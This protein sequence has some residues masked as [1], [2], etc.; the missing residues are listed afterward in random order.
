[1]KNKYLKRSGPTYNAVLKACEVES[2]H[3][4]IKFE[5]GFTAANLNN[6]LQSLIINKWLV[7]T[8][9]NNTILYKA[10]LLELPDTAFFKSTGH[11]KKEYVD[12]EPAKQFAFAGNPFR[13]AA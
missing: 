4:Q 7:K 10:T 8:K 3:E 13:Q 2:T 6:Y 9:I 11:R 1:M 5:T 12:C